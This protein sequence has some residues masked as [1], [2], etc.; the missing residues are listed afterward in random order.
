MQNRITPC[1]LFQ[2]L[3]TQH[4]KPGAQTSKIPGCILYSKEHELIKSK[5]GKNL[6]KNKFSKNPAWMKKVTVI[7]YSLTAFQVWCLLGE[8]IIRG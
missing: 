2:L 3:Y 1:E 4:I 5:D 8:D 7:N 6:N